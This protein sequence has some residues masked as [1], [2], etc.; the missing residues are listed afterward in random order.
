MIHMTCHIRPF[1]DDDGPHLVEILKRNN[2]LAFPDI[3]G[4]DAMLRVARCDAAV[5]LVAESN[6]APAGMIRAVY[7]GSRALIHLLSVDPDH[8]RR[9]V[10]SG[11]VEAAVAEL[12]RRGSSTC[13]VTVTE[14]SAPFWAQNGFSRLQVFLMLRNDELDRA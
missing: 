9:G 8:Q 4:L 6:G 10:G 12:R 2:Q 7:D 14:P 11:L 3:D 5:F 13:S 1:R